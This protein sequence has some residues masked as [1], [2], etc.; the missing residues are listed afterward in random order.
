MKT[1]MMSVALLLMGVAAAGTARANEVPS[2]NYVEAYYGSLS[3]DDIG[4]ALHGFSA[5]GV[6]SLNDR[7]FM[8][9][10][11]ADADTDLMGFDVGVTQISLGVGARWSGVTLSQKP[12]D[13]FVQ[14][15]RGELEYQVSGDGL[16]ASAN[17]DFWAAEAGF[18]VM[19]TPMMELGMSILHTK[20]DG[21][22]LVSGE[23]GREN[24]VQANVR[25]FVAPHCALNAKASSASSSNQFGL[26][27]SYSF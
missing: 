17:Q 16:H 18:R 26:G 25:Y 20:I 23:S 14:A 27:V 13:V 8:S 7:F 12:T 19:A 10:N 2:W 6:A 22:D 5:A 9:V 11:L 21:N 24:A 15:Y 3:R 1:K 4:E